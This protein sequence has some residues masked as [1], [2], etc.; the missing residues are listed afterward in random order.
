[1][2]FLACNSGLS[3]EGGSL[4]GINSCARQAVAVER[5]GKISLDD[6]RAARG[7]DEKCARPH[8]G[9]RCRIDHSSGLR[10][11]RTVQADHIRNRHQLIDATPT[12]ARPGRS[13]SL[14]RVGRDDVHA[15]RY[16]DLGHVAAYPAKA[17]DTRRLVL[18]LDQRRFPEAALSWWSCLVR[19]VFII[20]PRW[21]VVRGG[22]CGLPFSWRVSRPAGGERD[23][24]APGGRR[25][26]C[27]PPA[28]TTPPATR[29]VIAPI[30]LR[31]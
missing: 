14:R 1:M 19:I 27:A 3:K 22:C 20:T 12:E 9:Q 13:L 26:W 15:H 23:C 16:G 10:Q 7:V 25:L 18:Q 30:P 2:Q 21:L 17:D 11:E 6:Q 4:G 29:G 5:I 8:L 24:A 28:L 31:S